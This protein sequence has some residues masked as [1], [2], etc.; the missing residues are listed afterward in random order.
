MFELEKKAPELFW[1]KEIYLWKKNCQ[2]NTLSKIVAL[3]FKV[4]N[5]DV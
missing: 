5:N 3:L 2:K 4:P 1:R